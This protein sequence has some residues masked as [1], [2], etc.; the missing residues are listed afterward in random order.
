[1]PSQFHYPNTILSYYQNI[2]MSITTSPEAQDALFE[3]KTEE[4]LPP[5]LA[6]AAL[7][8]EFPP[9]YVLVGV[10]RLLTD[11]NLY[12]PAWDKCKHGT[13]RGAIVGGIWAR[14]HLFRTTVNSWFYAHHRR[15]SLLAFKRNSLN[16]SYP[17]QP[18][19]N[20][21]MCIRAFTYFW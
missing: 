6:R 16:Y 8:L 12:G 14:F 17:S 3:K 19:S 9:S 2:I 7:R 5:N 21:L 15:F 13:R 11:K 4:H 1:M 20:T 18:F 10:Y